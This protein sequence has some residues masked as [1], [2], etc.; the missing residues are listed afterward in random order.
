MNLSSDATATAPQDTAVFPA[1]GLSGTK[2]EAPRVTLAWSG[3]VRPRL[4][5]K[6]LSDVQTSRA[7]RYVALRRKLALMDLPDGSPM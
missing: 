4:L 7:V 2:S 6:G 1:S 5:S 3:N